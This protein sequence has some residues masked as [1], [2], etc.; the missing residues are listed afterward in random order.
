M[1][2]PVQYWQFKS[3][4]D[5]SKCLHVAYNQAGE[6]QNVDVQPCEGSSESVGTKYWRHSQDNQLI[7]RDSGYCI[8]PEPGK[9]GDGHNIHL[10]A[11]ANPNSRKTEFNGK[12]GGQLSFATRNGTCPSQVGTN[13]IEKYCNQNKYFTGDFKT[14]SACLFQD[15]PVKNT[16]ACRSFLQ[17]LANTNDPKVAFVAILFAIYGSVPQ[18]LP[19]S[20]AARL[21]DRDLIGTLNSSDMNKIL[22]GYDINTN[23]FDLANIGKFNKKSNGEN[24]NL[25]FSNNADTPT[26]QLDPVIINGVTFDFRQLCNV[27]VNWAQSKTGSTC[28]SISSKDDPLLPECLNTY[29]KNQLDEKGSELIKEKPYLKDFCTTI[30][31]GEDC[32]GGREHCSGYYSKY[33]PFCRVLYDKLSEPDKKGF[34]QDVCNTSH[35]RSFIQDADPNNVNKN[36]GLPEC[37]CFNYQLHPG[38][39]KIEKDIEPVFKQAPASCWVQFCKDANTWI[40]ENYIPQN[41]CPDI[42]YCNTN[43]INQNS[44]IIGGRTVEFKGNQACGNRPAPSGGGNDTPPSGSDVDVGDPTNMDS[45]QDNI[46]KTNVNKRRRRIIIITV[47]SVLFI[48]ILSLL[49]FILL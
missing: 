6:G 16:S 37:N 19:Q 39:K 23:T 2:Y 22:K 46:S 45:E 21:I 12:I 9:F 26:C 41:G 42:T 48:L 38:Y 49:L 32:Q 18:G 34:I 29:F 14:G 35:A 5:P 27:L 3:K 44:R 11:C 25:N 40:P 1:N 33:A 10:W 15:S 28:Q 17:F 31:S 36:K 8:N 24:F 13:V 4:E 43:F 47:V 30:Y 20:I 7:F